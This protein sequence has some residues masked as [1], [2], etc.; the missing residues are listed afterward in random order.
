MLHELFDHF[1]KTSFFKFMTFKKKKSLPKKLN[2]STVYLPI[3]IK[4]DIWV[5]PPP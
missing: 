2:L 4:W 3:V 5:V 1:K